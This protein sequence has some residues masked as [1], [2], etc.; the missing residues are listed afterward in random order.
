MNICDIVININGQLFDHV[1]TVQYLGIV[2]DDKL[3]WSYQVQAVVKNALI[4]LVCL[5]KYYLFSHM[6]LLYCTIMPLSSHVSVTVYFTGSIMIVLA[7][8]N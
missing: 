8:I 1:H 6:M 5:K 3:L 4:G 7:D 2:I